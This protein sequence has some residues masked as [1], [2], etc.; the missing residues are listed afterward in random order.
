MG[1]GAFAHLHTCVLATPLPLPLTSFLWPLWQISTDL[2]AESYPSPCPPGSERQEPRRAS[3][4]RILCGAPPRSNSEHERGC[5]P[6]WRPPRVRFQV[7]LPGTLTPPQSPLPAAPRL[8]FGGWE[9]WGL[10]LEF[11]L[12]APLHT[13]INSKMTKFKVLLSG[14]LRR[15]DLFPFLK[16]YVP[17]SSAVFTH[18]VF[19]PRRLHYAY[20]EEYSL[21][22][23]R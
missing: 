5:A 12:A 15:R 13:H 9:S 11:C 16:Q 2:A 10:S 4:L 7:R 18:L 8:E 21:H 19:T 22:K 1:K 20:L 14:C 6:G 23:L 17:G 3:P